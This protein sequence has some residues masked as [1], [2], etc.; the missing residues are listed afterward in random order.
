MPPVDAAAPFAA[1]L[2]PVRTQRRAQAETAA[3]TLLGRGKRRKCR[4]R[5]PL[6]SHLGGCRK[7]RPRIPACLFEATRRLP[8]SSSVSR[9]GEIAAR[10]LRSKGTQ[11]RAS[12]L[13]LTFRNSVVGLSPM[14]TGGLILGARGE[15]LRTRPAPGRPA[16]PALQTRGD[17]PSSDRPHDRR[18]DR[19]PPGGTPGTRLRP[20]S[21]A[22]CPP[23]P[24][25]R[26]CSIRASSR[27]HIGGPIPLSLP[28]PQ[29]PRGSA[30]SE[31]DRTA[32][33]RP[34]RLFRDGQPDFSIHAG[35][36]ISSA[37]CVVTARV[38]SAA[39]C[40]ELAHQPIDVLQVERGAHSLERGARRT[41]LHL[42][43][44]AIATGN[45]RLG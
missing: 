16:P 4:P 15:R 26:W 14:K 30:A 8:W 21:P 41:K 36:G 45:L 3:R 24:R 10:S 42:R 23:L 1:T 5:I 25:A 29:D 11:R 13:S 40:S 31:L 33:F 19:A 43:R 20:I 12:G 28:P 22:L 39:L 32:A 38:R 35:G 34:S 37:H 27:D 18:L 2:T 9:K 44:L 17:P 6:F 7:S